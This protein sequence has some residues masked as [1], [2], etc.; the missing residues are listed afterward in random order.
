MSEYYANIFSARAL[1][2]AAFAS[3]TICVT[4]DFGIASL[5]FARGNRYDPLEC[6]I[7]SSHDLLWDARLNA[8]NDENSAMESPPY[9]QYEFHERDNEIVVS[10]YGYELFTMGHNWCTQPQYLRIDPL[11]NYFYDRYGCLYPQSSYLL[12]FT[13]DVYDMA[14]RVPL[15]YYP[16]PGIDLR[17]VPL[18]CP[19]KRKKIVN[20]PVTPAAQAK[21]VK[22][23]L[24]ARQPARRKPAKIKVQKAKPKPLRNKQS[25][26]A[27]PAVCAGFL[28]PMCATRIPVPTPGQKTARLS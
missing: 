12:E 14:T 20:K 10:E 5:P 26:A 22:A 24:G 11:S 13:Y 8:F 15:V 17:L 1:V 28:D 9:P 19:L 16:R 2:S 25:N 21:V 4:T 23:I 7:P 18:S 3:N 27:V 6:H